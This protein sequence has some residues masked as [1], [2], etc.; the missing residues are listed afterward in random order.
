MGFFERRIEAYRRKQALRKLQRVIKRILATSIDEMMLAGPHALTPEMT[1]QDAA[2]ELIAKGLCAM[3]IMRDAQ[4]LGEVSEATFL[5]PDILKRGFLERPCSELMREAPPGI[6]RSAALKSAIDQFG[7][8]VQLVITDK[9]TVAGVLP[10]EL[11]AR[12]IDEHFGDFVEEVDILPTIDRVA[13]HPLDWVATTDPIAT[14]RSALE[15]NE[16]GCVLVRERQRTHPRGIVTARDFLA[17][18]AHWGGEIG[19]FECINIMKHPVISATPSR[20]LFEANHTMITK[21]F[22]RLPICEGAH[23]KGVLTLLDLV[24]HILTA[25]IE[26]EPLRA[27]KGHKA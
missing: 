20:D 4:I 3:P 23:C 26:T 14:V 18:L 5:H 12:R 21:G 10:I 2:K 13:L 19:R 17:E 7:K 6:E 15:K 27:E 11:I 16:G 22:R 9:K 24:R 25:E 1:L 8:R